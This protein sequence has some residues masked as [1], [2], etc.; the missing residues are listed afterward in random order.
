MRSLSSSSGCFFFLFLR[1]RSTS[2]LVRVQVS[3]SNLELKPL[4]KERGARIRRQGSWGEISTRFARKPVQEEIF[5]ISISL[6]VIGCSVYLRSV[7]SHNC[8]ISPFFIF[9]AFDSTQQCDDTLD[10]Q[11]ITCLLAL[12]HPTDGIKYE[13]F[14]ERRKNFLWLTQ[15]GIA[16]GSVRNKVTNS[17]SWF[18]PHEQQIWVSLVIRA[19]SAR[20]PVPSG[21]LTARRG[22]QHLSPVHALL[23][24]AKQSNVY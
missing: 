7:G 5:I 15:K 4:S 21:P 13:T 1:S 6:L 11:L 22:M 19:T 12:I 20:P 23:P 8:N 14:E 24:V 17:L 16:S 18:S 9:P 3:V 10:D 2:R